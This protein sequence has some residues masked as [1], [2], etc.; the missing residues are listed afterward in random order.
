M[1]K[2]N[3]Q[4]KQEFQ[5]KCFKCGLVGH[6]KRDC[7]SLKKAKPMDD[8]VEKT[9]VPAPV[10]VPASKVKIEAKVTVSRWGVEECT[11]KKEA[12]DWQK[13]VIKPGKNC[14]KCGIYGHLAKDCLKVDVCNRCGAEGHLARDCPKKDNCYRCGMS[15]HLAK[16]CQHKNG[17]EKKC[18]KCGKPGH[19][20]RD[21]LK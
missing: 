11:E 8:K 2:A 15:G 5:G 17:H 13:I 1:P 18:Y 4:P 10:P 21:C 12:S 14:F 7:P 16:D 20:A 3:E 19:M 9:E 6:M